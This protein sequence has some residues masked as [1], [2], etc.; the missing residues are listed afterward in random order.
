M[1][2]LKQTSP[3]NR[4]LGY[5][6]TVFVTRLYYNLESDHVGNLISLSFSISSVR[7]LQAE[8]LAVMATKANPNNLLFFI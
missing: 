7:S 4:T 5:F 8:K 6:N 2:L 1:K 3:M